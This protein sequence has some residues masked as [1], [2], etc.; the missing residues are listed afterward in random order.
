MDG[1]G[2]LATAAIKA[3]KVSPSQSVSEAQNQWSNEAKALEDTNVIRDPHIIEAKSIIS[4]EEKGHYFIFQWADGG[5]LRDLYSDKRRVMLDSEF[6]R[7]IIHQLLG[8]AGALNKLH[9]YKRHS[10]DNGSYRHGD[11]KPENIL[12]FE[13]GSR[14]GALKISD[15]GLAKHHMYETAL[16][17]PTVTRY[18]TTLYE[19]PEVLDTKAARSRQYDI[20]SMGCVILELII[21]LLYGYEE[22]ERFNRSMRV[23]LGA[24][25][26]YWVLDE[27]DAK[28]HSACIHPSVMACMDIVG[29]DPECVGETAIGDLLKIVKTKLL[30]VPL[31][32]SSSTFGQQNSQ[33]P[34]GCR[35]RAEDLER[36][37]KELVNKG[38][39]ND[40][41]WFSRKS[42]S[43]LAG[44]VSSIPTPNLSASRFGSNVPTVRATPGG[45]RAVAPRLEVSFILTLHP[46]S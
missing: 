9:N 43:G 25:S 31:P 35:A 40:R 24:S 13:D 2:R 15:L 27:T 28:G 23:A 21:W 20:W 1:S 39:S 17:D 5:S 32:R 36:A 22:L 46:S 33:P 41:Y 16:R 12:R 6:V 18:G 19:P 14:V 4:W 26:P 7:E 11:L 45:L 10:K 3:L 30:V 8:L 29:R 38:R 44:P 34:A 37:L 42:R